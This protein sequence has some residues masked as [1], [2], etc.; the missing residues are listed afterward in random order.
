MTTFIL[1]GGVAGL[2]AGMASGLP[3]LEAAG[4]PGG[5]C[6][7]YYRRPDDPAR[8]SEP[9]AAEDAY[10][11]E[12]GGGHWIF[13]ADEEMRSLLAGL[14]SLRRY[15]RRS[16]VYFPDRR[17]HVPF[18]LQGHLESLGPDIAARA[19]GE[20]AGAGSGGDTFRDW[21]QASFGPTLCREFFFSF[22]Q[23]YTAGLYAT[24]APEDGYKSPTA[25]G[26]RGYNVEFDYPV[27]GL[28]AL[29]RAMAARC[30]IE[31]ASRI[32]A[33][34][35]KIRRLHLAGGRVLAYDRLIST[36]PLNRMIELTGLALKARPDPWTSVLVLNI[37]AERSPHTPDAHWTYLAQSRSGLYRVGFYDNVEPGFLPRAERRER[38]YAALYGERAFPGGQQPSE[39]EIGLHA[40]AAVRELQE[41]GFIGQLRLLDP[42]W[43][44]VAYTWRWPGSSW[45]EEALQALADHGIAQL[46]RYGRW[47]F[48]GIAQSIRD[49]L[50]AGS[51][52]VKPA[53]GG[54][55]EGS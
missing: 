19:A 41:W 5:I 15:S 53:G 1:G 34:D 31:Y 39:E 51:A 49:G 9:P 40:T 29:V 37:V 13:G 23:R 36:L 22:H 14:G 55:R 46:G 50:S 6:A 35:P 43:I 48:Q 24:I 3:I 52:A 16:S 2:A 42:T 20:M 8:L 33:I 30:R 10:R 17:L 38:P 21:L 27:A 28:D 26:A 12:L 47:H 7:S 44:D 11:F 45:R 18:P 32:V 4:H 25:R 54:A